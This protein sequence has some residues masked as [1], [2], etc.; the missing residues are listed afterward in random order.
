MPSQ[1][2][3]LNVE[4]GDYVS[5]I[6]GFFFAYLQMKNDRDH[7]KL[8]VVTEMFGRDSGGIRLRA[9]ASMR[10]TTET[11]KVASGFFDGRVMNLTNFDKCCLQLRLVKEPHV[12]YYLPI[13]FNSIQINFCR[14]P[15]NKTRGLCCP[16][17]SGK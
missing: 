3:E 17:F 2:V 7:D 4:E 14:S 12:P 6:D 16:W 11:W 1:R 13:I 9:K 10:A 5:I 8:K 15:W